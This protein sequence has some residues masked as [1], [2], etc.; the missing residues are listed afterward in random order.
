M[1]RTLALRRAVCFIALSAVLLLT[2]DGPA[3]RR[4]DAASP[5]GRGE[6]RRSAPGP[7]QVIVKSAEGKP[8]GGVVVHI[9]GRY[10]ST[11]ADGVAILDG[12]PSGPCKL[13]IEHNG[14]DRLEQA[15]DLPEGKR[16]VTAITL[17]AATIATVD[18]AVT[19]EGDGRPLAGAQIALVPVAVAAAVQGRFDFL[20]DWGGKFNILEIPAGKYK[21]RVSAEGCADKAQDVEIKK[22]MGP[23]AFALSRVSENASLKVIARDSA[24]DKPI[25]G[26]KVILAE[27]WPKGVIATATTDGSGEVT[28]K[29]MKLARLNWMDAKGNLSA[30]RRAATVRV[31][32]ADH[33]SAVA[34]VSIGSESAATVALNP[35]T[36]LVE[37]G[38]NEKLET[39]MAIPTGAPVEF[40]INKIGRQA[41]F[42]FRLKHPAAVRVK[43][44]PKNPL[45]MRVWVLNTK[46]IITE[47]ISDPQVDNV[48]DLNLPA[49]EFFV[50]AAHWG[51]GQASADPMT[52]LVSQQTAADPSEPNNSASA[53]RVI[54]AGEEMRGCIFPV[55]D[56]DYFRFTMD[57]PGH[58]R[59]TIPPQPLARRVFVRDAAGAVRGDRIADPGTPLELITQLEKGNYTVSVQQWGDNGCSLEPYTLKMEVIGDDN[60]D[61]PKDAPGRLAAVRTLQLGTLVGGTIQPAGDYDRYAVTLPGSG[62][63]HAR[64]IAPYAPRLILRSA[65][66][67]WLGDRISDPRVPGELAWHCGGPQTVYLDMHHWGDGQSSPSPY[68]LSTWW[69]PCDESEVAGRNESFEA[70][71]PVE[72]GDFMRGTIAPNGDVDFFRVEVDHPG[73]LHVQGPGPVAMRVF[74]Y[75]GKKRQITDQIRDPNVPLDMAPAVFPGEY[76]IA[77]HN[78]GDGQSSPLPYAM[79][80]WLDRADPLERVPLNKDPVR[81][82]K[83]GE[84]RP[85]MIEHPGDRDHFVFDAAKAGKFALRWRLPLST[86]VWVYDDRS[87]KLV[88]ELICDP[89]T[90][91]RIVLEPK[92][93]T[94]YRA[95]MSN[96]GDGQAAMSWGW[97]VADELGRDIVAETVEASVDPFDPTSVTFTRKELKPY[98]MAQSASLDADGDGK[99]DVELPAGQGV[100]YRYK[101]EGVYPAA[102]YLTGANGTR[103]TARTWVQAI[104]T[105]ERKG[106]YINVNFPFEGQMVERDEPAR[107]S[108]VSYSGARVSSLALAVDGKE[109]GRAY[110]SPFSIEVP[111]KSLGKGEHTLSFAAA[112]GKGG[113]ATV[114]RKVRVSEY[115]GL[116]PED[117]ATLSGNVVNVTW[118]GSGFGPARV[119]YRVK[120]QEWSEVVGQNATDRRVALENLE[121]GKLY[122]VQP[123]GDG[124]PGPIRT[125]TRVKGLA[126][127]KTTY[128]AGIARDYDQKLGVS[129]RNNGDKPLTVRLE[130]GKPDSD[131][132]LVGF[133]GEGSE[134]VPVKLAPGEERDFM[135]GLSAQDATKPVYQFPIRLTSDAGLA[136]EAKVE[137]NV[138]LP[139]VKLEWETVGPAPDGLGQLFRLHNKGDTVTDLDVG[140]NSPDMYVSPGVK[141]GM[142]LGGQSM[143]VI[144]RPRLHEEFKSA[145]AKLTAKALDK[146]SQTDAQVSLKDGQRIF[147]V[148][149]LAGQGAAGRA[150]TLEQDILAAR[151]LAGAYLNPKYVDW[152][153]KQNPQDTEGDG[154]PDRWTIMDQK[155]DILWVGD[156]T[157]GDAEI[158]FVHADIGNDGQ[159][160]YSAFKTRDG[161]EPTNLVE[162]WLEMGFKLPW[163]RSAYEK[164]DVDIVMNGKVVGKLREAIPEGNYTFRVPPSAIQFNEAGVPEG[165][166]VEIQSRHLRGGHFVVNSDFRIKTRMTGTRAWTVAGSQQEAEAIARKSPGLSVEGPDYAVSSAEM[167]LEGPAT[168]VKGSDVAITVP[169]R[170]VGATRTNGVTMALVRSAPGGEGVELSRQAIEDVPL[171]GSV[172]VRFAWKAGAGTHSLKVVIDPASEIGDTNRDNNEAILSLT[173]PGDDAKPTIKVLE[174]ADG[175]A[176]KQTAVAVRAEAKDD[177]G[178]ARVDVRIDSGLWLTLPPAKEAGQYATSALLQPGA[179]TLAIRATDG[180]GNTV[181]QAVR[182]NVDAPMPDIQILVPAEGAK[183]GERQT[184]VKIKAGESAVVAAVR[185]NGGAWQ[186]VELKDGVGEKQLDVPFGRGKIEAMAADRK[187]V[188]RIA[189]GNID[190]TAQP[191]ADQADPTKEQ[192]TTG[193]GGNTAVGGGDA[194]VRGGAG[195]AT[196]AVDG[197]GPVDVFGPPNTIAGQASGAKSPAAPVQTGPDGTKTGGQPV[198]DNGGGKDGGQPATAEPGGQP[199]TVELGEAGA[200][201]AT[202]A[203]PESLPLV[204]ENIPRAGPPDGNPPVVNPPAVAPPVV[205]PPRTGPVRPAGGFV[206]SQVKQ[207]DSYCTNRPNIKVKFR[208]PDWLKRKNLTYADKKQYD[209]MVKK[210]IDRMKAQGIDTSKLEKFQEAMR[211]HI[212]GMNSPDELPSFLES[213]GFSGPKPTNPEELKAWR[214]KMEQAAD[215]WYLR[216]LSSGDPKLVA[217]GL[218]ARAEAIGQYDKAM[219]DYAEASVETIQA[220]QKLVQDVAETLPVVGDV[221]DVWAAVTGEAPLTGEQLSALERVLRLGFVLGPMGIEQLVKRSPNAQLILEGLGEMG[222][223]MGKSGKEMMAKMLGRSTKEVDEGMEAI[224]K[225]LTKERHIIGESLEDKAARAAREFAKT[226]EGIAEATRRMKDAAEAKDVIDNLR[227]FPPESAEF[228]AAVKELQGNKTA[229]GLINTN[230]IEDALRQKVNGEVKSIYKGTDAGV[231]ERLEGAFKGKMNADDIKKAADELGVTPAEL[232]KFR[233][234]VQEAAKKAGVD[235]ADVVVDVKTITN[236]RPA[237]PGEVEVTSVGRD[238]DVT[239]VIKT[240]DGKELGDIGHN[241][242]KNPYE[243]EF[244]KSSGKGELPRKPDG[245]VDLDAVHSHAHEMD[246]TVT[247]KGHTEAYNTGEVQL[248]D[249]LDKGKTP[250]ITRIEDV[251]DTVSWKSEEWFR[252]AAANKN[253]VIGSR[254]AAEGMRQATKQYDDLVLSRV[255]QY[256]LSPKNVPPRLQ[257]SMDIFRKVKDGSMSVGQAEAALKAIGTTKERAVKDMATFLEGMEKTTGV[258]WRRVKSAELVNNLHSLPG[259]GTP[260]W[261][262]EALGK[263]NSALANGHISGPQFHKLRTEVMQG[264]VSAAKVADPKDWKPAL[265]QWADQAVQR[266]L[267]SQAEKAAI[268]QQQ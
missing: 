50:R 17:T 211:K 214:E 110:T 188:Q 39:A 246:Q 212:R 209:E 182:V 128:G 192:A 166:E 244:W 35:T 176:L 205:E 124:E 109:I 127:G 67:P 175:A 37:L 220:N 7:V 174:P 99:A 207:S 86:R 76:Y 104:G 226:P 185:V 11:A 4:A 191:T 40:K 252:E 42:K 135:L 49:G 96:W 23:L 71:T 94:R 59:F 189:Q 267:I 134:G 177:S 224:G 181:E 29:D 93:A 202:D 142:F 52:L 265:Q 264:Y 239:Y 119:K 215:A 74:I 100:T 179:H 108:A 236:K 263:I 254:Q 165:N 56:Q 221:V 230:K 164:H 3:Q 247:S 69:E 5:A 18:G 195:G 16:P 147:G 92:G 266:R 163:A 90:D 203:Q 245:S 229:Q 261:T 79:R 60:V 137:I 75:D 25:A 234:Q 36:K 199:A 183:L 122:E 27:A 68:V 101:A 87:G 213:I 78:W 231:K 198:G 130:C 256:G 58:G 14:F 12:M 133:V 240:K 136:D 259:A 126:F 155:E 121:P 162:C 73:Y 44:G 217:E 210:F 227:K 151:A 123:L 81:L 31:E 171:S 20:S 1:P 106:I 243:Q 85:F 66:G 54:H 232:Q 32:A 132:L 208:L 219:Q 105:R 9:G 61:D 8:L 48:Q 184:T 28:F 113:K 26:A 190:C 148:Q 235:P 45:A 172:P 10:A 238:R 216:L 158:D 233:D 139:V 102:V 160:D 34:P 46:G 13:I 146:A 168:V 140:S 156:D 268:D 201:P 65:A 21:A 250:T 193:G 114:Q 51:D 145:A 55:G 178:I 118:S 97:I 248:N 255:K 249:F 91:G 241:M 120:D 173:V 228:K 150:G 223:S 196:V 237:K 84:A 197:V 38:G 57:R 262:G 242:S 43:L 129:V 161:W 117:G 141:H 152:S 63:I 53:A 260:A 222:E 169:L 15:I 225:F 194:G 204:Q 33:E 2:I 115:F 80:V 187:G 143:E 88:T 72:L 154:K 131:T 103:S 6:A 253:P 144:A 95:E 149:L 89:N 22:G 107:A 47:R 62:V 186:A 116:L 64:I 83:L 41:Y 19:L 257:T 98:P 24:T 138:K 125:I 200:A 167:R 70:A 30:S 218:K 82:L 77:I 170:N 251:K 153:K 206:S 258:G 159:F 111:W 157:D 180:S 112:D